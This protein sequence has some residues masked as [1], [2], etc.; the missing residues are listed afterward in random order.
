MTW[1]ALALALLLSAVSAAALAQRR[2]EFY[3]APVF[4]ESKNYTFEGGTNVKTDTGWGFTVG[5]AH[6]F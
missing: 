6:V 1:K 3:A 5:F 4:T 2:S